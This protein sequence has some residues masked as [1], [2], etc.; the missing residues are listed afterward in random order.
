MSWRRI[1]VAL[2]VAGLCVGATALSAAWWQYSEIH[3]ARTGPFVLDR[4]AAGGIALRTD[5]TATRRGKPVLRVH[6]G[7]DIS[8]DLVVQSIPASS[9]GQGEVVSDVTVELRQSSSYD[10]VHDTTPPSPSGVFSEV[11]T[12]DFQPH[13]DLGR[14]HEPGRY[15]ILVAYT[16]RFTTGVCAQPGSSLGG[17]GAIGF[18]VV[19]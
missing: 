18:L 15:R 7:E 3:A 2:T 4:C 16:A 1:V 11:S 10:P 5:T 9:Q 6:R 19:H 13:V 17:S 12:P 14:L 8:V